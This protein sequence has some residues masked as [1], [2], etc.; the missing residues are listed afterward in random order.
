MFRR[1]LGI[2]ISLALAS[3]LAAAAESAKPVAKL[4][5][6][7]IVSRNVEARGGLQAW[8]A[9]QAMS[10]EGKMGVGGNQRAALAM[11]EPPAKP[12]KKT[13][14]QTVQQMVYSTRP[15]EEVQLPFLMDLKR[16]HKQ[17]FEL[18]FAGKT[19]VQVWDGN[20]GWKVR[21]YLNRDEVEPYT[22]DETKVAST[23]ADLDGYL[24]DHAAKGIQIGLAGT[25]KVEGRDA[26]KLKLTP[27]AG[28]PIHVW[29]D[30]QTFLETKIEG[31]PH[32]MDGTYH[33]VEV[34]YRDYRKVNGLQIPFVLETKVLPVERTAAG[35]RDTPVPVERLTIEKVAVNPK[36]DDSPFVRPQIAAAVT[37]R[38]ASAGK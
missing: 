29:I 36:L 15:K 24:I 31:E 13:D 22:A 6:A 25:E 17:R 21:P 2:C 9:V 20:H 35:F 19:A 37:Q 1:S 34:Y 14:M 11:P 4:T 12:G 30:A 18:Q 27:K 8:R 3:S 32:R 26:Y 7:E 10:I 33:P 38:V 28:H 16:S 5:A 23:Q